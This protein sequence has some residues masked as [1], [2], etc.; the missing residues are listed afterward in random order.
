M[1]NANKIIAEF[2]E[3]LDDSPFVMLGLP[4]QNAH[5]MPMSA[6]FDDDIPNTLFFYTSTDNRAVQALPQTSKAMVQYAS[7]G[8]DFFACLSGRLST[9]NDR[10]LIDKFW[11]N[12]VE[13]WYENGKDDPKLVMLRMDLEDAEMWEA[14]ADFIGMFKMLTGSTIDQE[15]QEDKHLETKM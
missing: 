9:T 11:S 15:K 14:G 10:D 13:A 1:T 7:K 2:W 8:H 6:V 5:S 3:K 12:P 4:E